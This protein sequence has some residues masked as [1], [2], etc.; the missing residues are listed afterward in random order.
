MDI[1]RKEMAATE[2]EDGFMATRAMAFLAFFFALGGFI[3]SMTGLVREPVNVWMGAASGLYAVGGICAIIAVIVWATNVYPGLGAGDWGYAFGVAAA[4][5]CLALISSCLVAVPS[6]KKD[7]F[8]FSG[9][10]IQF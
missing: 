2:R 10:A 1:G 7:A 4:A 6:L 5:G 3:T 8:G 9:R